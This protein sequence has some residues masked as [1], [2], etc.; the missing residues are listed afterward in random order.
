MSQAI[1]SAS[2]A[3]GPG[4]APASRKVARAAARVASA[5]P[6]P[7]SPAMSVRTCSTPFS[8]RAGGVR[9]YGSRPPPAQ[10]NPGLRAPGRKTIL[11]IAESGSAYRAWFFSSGPVFRAARRLRSKT[12][13]D[14]LDLQVVADPGE[15]P[16]A[17][18]AALLHSP[19]R[20]LDSAH[21]PAV[22]PDRTGF[23][24]PGE[25]ERAGDVAGIDPRGQPIAKA[26]R[27]LHG[28][29]LAFDL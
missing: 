3:S 17:A 9:V 16:F 6:P 14:I 2:Q 13:R 29:V 15:A 23:E 7:A 20:R 24:P 25:A 5:R 22:D 10:P 21:P 4:A 18:D 1:P 26:V 12:D 11:N 8:S 28:V 19:G 27:D